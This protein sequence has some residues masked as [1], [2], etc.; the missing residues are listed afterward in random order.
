VGHKNDALS[1]GGYPAG[2]FPEL[3]MAFHIQAI[4]RLIQY[5]DMRVM[6]KCP[7]YNMGLSERWDISRNFIT[8]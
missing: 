6:D 1:I 3:V 2:Q 7:A 4:C 8:S 5:K